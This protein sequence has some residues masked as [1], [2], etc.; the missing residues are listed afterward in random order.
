M[1]LRGAKIRNIYH[2]CSEMSNEDK[3]PLMVNIPH[4]QRPY[5]WDEDRIK[6]LISDFFEHYNSNSKK[7]S[8]TE[9]KKY[10]AGSIVTVRKN[11]N[12]DYLDLIDGQQ[13]ITTVYLVNYL[14]FL[15]LR[16][17]LKQVIGAM[18]L[19]KINKNLDLMLNCY[20][21]LIQKNGINT[22][23]I[24]NKIYHFENEIERFDNQQEKEDLVEEML[25]Y[26]MKKFKL[27]RIYINSDEEY[28]IEYKEGLCELIGKEDINLKY[29]RD[30]LNNKLKN[31][32]YRIN[33]KLTT[34]EGPNFE[35]INRKEIDNDLINTYVNALN[36]IYNTFEEY[37]DNNSK[38]PLDK[39]K[40]MIDKIDLFLQNLNFC[41]IE[42]G[43]T[44]DAYTL[45]E[46]LND[47]ALEVDDLDLIKNL[48]YK[49]YCLKSKEDEE[50][51]DDN[52]EKL[53]DL[54]GD[55]IFTDNTGVKKQKT[56]SFLGTVFLTGSN[57][58]KFNDKEEY[59]KKLKEE[60]LDNQTD[61]NYEKIYYNFKV[62]Q[63]VKEIINNYGIPY[64]KREISSLEA[65]NN[66]RV[67][68]TYRTLHLLNSVKQY[69]VMPALVNIIL[70]KFMKLN[71]GMLDICQFRDFIIQL[72]QDEEHQDDRFKEI[73]ECAHNLWKLV[74]LSDSY[75]KPRD[76]AKDIICSIN[77][78]DFNNHIIKLN[79]ELFD[80]AKKEF[81]EWTSRWYK[82]TKDDLRIKLL[83]LKL[84]CGKKQNGKIVYYNYHKGVFKNVRNLQ[85]D[86]F[87]PKNIQKSHPEKYFTP[88]TG[89]RDLY[90]DKLGNFMLLEKEKN[91]S[92]S[93]KPAEKSFQYY[94]K[95]GVDSDHWLVKEM[96]ELLN[97]HSEKKGD[98]KIPTEEFFNERKNRLQDYFF[99]II[100]KK[101]REDEVIIQEVDG[102][103][104]SAY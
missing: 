92:L 84:I 87:E 77:D 75:K 54:W 90:V 44:N 36:Y 66:P 58:I 94:G 20:N 14:K 23:K 30:S 16:A 24:E 4:Y 99:T 93:N 59:R 98:I 101:L 96:K 38:N 3:S 1:D 9:D 37:T 74:M 69:G 18:R 6:L 51:K 62:F 26:F 89:N 67:S 103:L 61:Y 79:Q 76:F 64:Q 15:L 68:I 82:N 97:N 34:E 104:S 19:T 70:K 11:E 33:I 63:A 29:S 5:K 91:A 41:V 28:Y 27:P 56:I 21:D 85:L 7:N 25:E 48:F 39:T 102:Q 32:L 12:S 40:E 57:S 80:E 43:N 46:V 22:T 100:N 42:T 17:Y 52:I 83:F 13:R 65:E 10:F 95:M 53:E 88:V 78:K 2:L 47:R 81:S 60:Y 86:H 45:F 35:V 49:E 8:T 50:I 31:A 55:K 71:N 72:K 73:H